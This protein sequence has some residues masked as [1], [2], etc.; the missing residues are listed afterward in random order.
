MTPLTKF[1]SEIKQKGTFEL[2]SCG[3][4]RVQQLK[5]FCVPATEHHGHRTVT[6]MPVVN[7]TATSCFFVVKD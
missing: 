4:C 2:L 5:D 1:I 3:M 6:I 7:L